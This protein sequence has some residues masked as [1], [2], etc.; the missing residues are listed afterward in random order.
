APAAQKSAP[1]A[2]ETAPKGDSAP[3]GEKQ[4][5]SRAAGAPRSQKGEEESERAARAAR[6][7]AAIAEEVSRD[8]GAPK[9]DR[10]STRLNSCPVFPYPPRFRSC[11]RR[12]KIC[13]RGA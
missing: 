9:R 12:T 8:G 3:A 6:A 5:P 7:A 10:K 13:A 1:A 4:Q 11:A 2:R